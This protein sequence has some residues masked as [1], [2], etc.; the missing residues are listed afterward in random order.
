MIL[1][2]FS[3]RV[4][5]VPDKKTLGLGKKVGKNSFTWRKKNYSLLMIYADE[6]MNVHCAQYDWS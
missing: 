4:C 6:L 2:N 5:M 3:S 1:G